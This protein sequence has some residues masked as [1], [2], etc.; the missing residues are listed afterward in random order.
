MNCSKLELF[1]SSPMMEVCPDETNAG[2]EA[3]DHNDL[4]QDIIK[5]AASS[6]GFFRHQQKDEPDLTVEEKSKI[7]SDLLSAKPGLFLSRFGKF[8]TEDHLE[9][10]ESLTTAN[11]ELEFYLRQVRQEQCRF[12]NQ[13]KVKNRRYAALKNMLEANDEYFSAEAMKARH[14]LLHEQLVGRFL[15][16]E[17]REAEARPDMSNCS[18]T[19]IILD[20]MDLNKERDD[21][22]RMKEEE[23]V[24]EFDTDDEES[25]NGNDD[26]EL[27]KLDGGR[28]FLK[29]QFVKSVYQG[30]LEG[31]DVGFDYR[32][33]DND[34]SLDDLDTE[35]RD[36]E[37]KYFE[38]SDIDE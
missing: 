5:T 25:D 18:L 2:Q 4:L 30:F 37:D 12:I 34:E 9:Y 38:D 11:Y 16:E 26:E 33:I 28:D 19:K 35:Q 22:K 24:E 23:D 6:E 13:N 29:Q 27:A 7:A 3:L 32:K 21:R 36:A 20:H 31:K 10:F 14:P 1:N 15:T 8:L 17:E